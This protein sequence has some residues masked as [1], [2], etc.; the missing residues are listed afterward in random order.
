M[1]TPVTSVAIGIR[2]N[3]ADLHAIA[4]LGGAAAALTPRELGDFDTV[5]ALGVA[6]TARAPFGTAHCMASMACTIRA[7]EGF[8]GIACCPMRSYLKIYDLTSAADG[9][10]LPPPGDSAKATSPV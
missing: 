9:T 2:G 6:V 10:S 1:V 4:T 7:R 3:Q 8:S 5:S